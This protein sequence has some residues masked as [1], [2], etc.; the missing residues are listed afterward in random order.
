MLKGLN[1]FKSLIRKEEALR[2]EK[3]ELLSRIIFTNTIALH[4]IPKSEKVLVKTIKNALILNKQKCLWIDLSICDSF[5]DSVYI[6]GR[7]KDILHNLKRIT[8][9]IILRQECILGFTSVSLIPGGRSL[10]NFI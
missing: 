10:K 4:K 8:K 9:M 6:F 2:K 3:Q 5:L 7:E 1:E